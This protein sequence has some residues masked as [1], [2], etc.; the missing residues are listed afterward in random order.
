MQDAFVK[1]FTTGDSTQTLAF[2]II[3]LLTFLLGILVF[4]LFM[5]FPVTRKLRRLNVEQEEENTV[6][7]KDNKDLSERYTVAHAKLNRVQEDL[8]T[9]EA[10]LKEKNEKVNQQTKQIKLLEDELVLYKDHARNFKEAN[11]KLLETYQEMSKEQESM[12]VKMEDMKGLIEEVEQE[13][14][15]MIKGHLEVADAKLIAEK[16]LG[17]TAS[18]LS[19]AEETIN[20]L[21]KDLDAA[22]EQ[23]AELKKMLLTVEATQQLDG[24]NDE[25]LKVQLVGLKSHIQDLEAENSDLMERLAPYLAKEHQEETQEKEMEEL[26]VNLL[27]DAEQNMEQDGFYID[28]DESQLIEDKIY[29]EKALKEE[30]NATEVEEREMPVLVS[31][32]EKEAMEAALTEAEVAMGMQGFYEDIEEAVLTQIEEEQVEVSD[33]DLMEQ[34]LNNT[35]EVFN[36][37]LFFDEDISSDNLIENPTLLET[38]LAKLDFA[39]PQADVAAELVTLESGDHKDM[40]DAL[41]QADVAMSAEGLYAPIDTN[42]LMASSDENLEEEE[43]T[44]DPIGDVVILQEIGRSIPKAAPNQKDNLQKIDGIGSFIE[45]RLNELGIYTYEQISQFDAAFIAKL[46][47]VLG[48]SEQ[49]IARDQWVEQAQKILGE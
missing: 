22:L 34:H 18:D 21:K 49:T 20:L 3:L 43:E 30:D 39:A 1:L 47:A 44:N 12:K 35:A 48:F 45:Q 6:L 14:A 16:K 7:K 17:T 36:Q 40:E 23:K 15:E 37:A 25:D 42:K 29:L 8:Q 38:E 13:K 26:L 31:V 4:A 46:G 19:K 24:T 11:E 33:E 2:F 9:A 10:N 28:Y 41:E 32:D 27:V 5:Y